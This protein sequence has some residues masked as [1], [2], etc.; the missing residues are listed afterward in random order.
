MSELIQKLT[1]KSSAPVEQQVQSEQLHHDVHEERVDQAAGMVAG[2]GVMPDGDVSNFTGTREPY[3][4]GPPLP[5]PSGQRQPDQQDQSTA[6]GEHG[7]PREDVEDAAVAVVAHQLLGSR[8]PP[9]EEE[10]DR[11]QDAVHDLDADEQRDHRDA[12]DH[13]DE[14]RRSRSSAVITPTNTG[15]SRGRRPI[16]FSKPSVSAMT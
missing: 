11:Q 16:P 13:R 9:D 14:R 8:Q 12:G 7:Q 2:E 1:G 3:P 4:D 6:R 5:R 10:R 15:A